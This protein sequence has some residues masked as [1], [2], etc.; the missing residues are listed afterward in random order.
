VCPP[1]SQP[2]TRHDRCVTDRLMDYLTAAEIA[3]YY[4]RPLGTIRRL[5]ST[6]KWVRTHRKIRPVMY[7]AEDVDKTFAR[8]R[9]DT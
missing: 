6:D 4:R 2:E 5:A 8:L 7:R 1:G 3:T 9:L